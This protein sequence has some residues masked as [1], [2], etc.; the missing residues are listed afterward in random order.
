MNVDYVRF[1]ST[2][3]HKEIRA[4][5]NLSV[6]LCEDTVIILIEFLERNGYTLNVTNDELYEFTIAVASSQVDKEQVTAWVRKNA[7]KKKEE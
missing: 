2:Q 1:T 3:T 5:L 7:I 4:R 6:A